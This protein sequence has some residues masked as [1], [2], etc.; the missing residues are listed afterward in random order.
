MRSSTKQMN[1]KAA[2]QAAV[3]FSIL[4][5]LCGALHATEKADPKR[6]QADVKRILA[7][8]QAQLTEDYL[9]RELMLVGQDITT[10][11]LPTPYADQ[12]LEIVLQNR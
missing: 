4:V 10:D 9:V 1:I 12:R 11:S 6:T 5:T 3:A 7:E 2:V 8:Q